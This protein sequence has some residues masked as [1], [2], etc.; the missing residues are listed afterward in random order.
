MAQT[1]TLESVRLGIIKLFQD[2]QV[3]ADVRLYEVTDKGDLMFMAMVNTANITLD[4]IT[5]ASEVN[6]SPL[7]PLKFLGG[8]I[9]TSDANT[10]Y[11]RFS[12]GH[13][14]ITTGAIAGVCG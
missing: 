1:F 7:L 11:F 6:G 8:H 3:E 14:E 4:V 13:D 10:F 9:N 5:M 2:K 12:V